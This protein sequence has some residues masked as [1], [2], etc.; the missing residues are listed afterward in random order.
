MTTSIDTTVRTWSLLTG[1]CHKV[2]DGHRGAV[3]CLALDPHN[4]RHAYTGGADGLIKLWD[5]ITGDL[6]KDLKGHEDTIL[7]LITHKRILYSGSAD[8][9]ARAWAIEFGECTRIYYRNESSVSC[10][11]YYDGIGMNSLRPMTKALIFLLLFGLSLQYILVAVTARPVS[12]T[13]TQ[14]P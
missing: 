14:A 3:N 7:C 1:E 13:P 8:R 4:R 11:Q 12:T 5:L 10:V 9:T 2:L 6:I